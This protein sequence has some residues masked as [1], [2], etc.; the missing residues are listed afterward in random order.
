M[1]RRTYRNQRYTGVPLETRGCL[2]GYDAGADTL[3]LWSASQVPHLV[4]SG[5]A[6]LLGFPEN[7]LRVA[8]RSPP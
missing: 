8:R 1:L 7:R 2:A 3:T 4:R 5:V 6:E